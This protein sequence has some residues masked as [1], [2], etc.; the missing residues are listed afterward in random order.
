MQTWGRG[1]PSWWMEGSEWEPGDQVKGCAQSASRQDPGLPGLTQASWGHVCPLTLLQTLRL[2][3]SEPEAAGHGFLSKT[4]VPL[5][6]QPQGCRW[7]L[8]KLSD[9][10]RAPCHGPGAPAWEHR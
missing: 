2:L 5:T 8:S 1:T 7:P 9:L 10:Q 6:S 3:L 4:G